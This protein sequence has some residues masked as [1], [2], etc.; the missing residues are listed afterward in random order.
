VVTRR[1]KH[2]PK[3]DSEWREGLGLFLRH[4]ETEIVYSLCVRRNW[5]KRRRFLIGD[6]SGR[7]PVSLEV[8]VANST[9]GAA[10]I[11]IS[12]D[13]ELPVPHVERVEAKKVHARIACSFLVEDEERFEVVSRV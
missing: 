10:G 5:P 6:A 9:L 13:V 8:V 4:P 2:R 1:F 7:M 3:D 11:G 12:N